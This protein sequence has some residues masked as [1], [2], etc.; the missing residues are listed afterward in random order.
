MLKAFFEF[1]PVSSIL[2]EETCFF[3]PVFTA[4]ITGKNRP[5][6][7]GANPAINLFMRVWR[8][9]RVIA[10]LKRQSLTLN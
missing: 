2:V 1:L 8:R 10:R 9:A 6:K 7:K 5:R 4:E 3:R